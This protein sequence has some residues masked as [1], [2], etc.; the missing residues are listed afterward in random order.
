MF[1]LILVTRRTPSF[2]WVVLVVAYGFFISCFSFIMLVFFE[3]SPTHVRI[4]DNIWVTL[5][6]MILVTL[7]N[8]N[9]TSVQKNKQKHVKEREESHLWHCGWPMSPIMLP[10]YYPM[11]LNCWDTHKFIVQLSTDKL[12]TDRKHGFI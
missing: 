3:W 10:K 1:I 5:W 2:W 6:L 11:L 8:H 4:M 7:V 12:S 9:V